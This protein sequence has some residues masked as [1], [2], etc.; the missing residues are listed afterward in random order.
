MRE[1]TGLEQ[2][3]EAADHIEAQGSRDG[4]VEASGALRTVAVSLY[5]IANDLLAVVR[6]ADR[7]GRDPPAGPAAGQLDHAGQGPTR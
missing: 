4:L 7:L 2:L 3:A 1:T 6:T 5:K